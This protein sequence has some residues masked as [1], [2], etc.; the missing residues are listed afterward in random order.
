MKRTLSL[1][2]LLVG[3]IAFSAPASAKMIEVIGI[4]VNVDITT[5][6]KV[7]IV[8]L[9]KDAPAERGGLVNANDQ[10]IAV[11]NVP[12]SGFVAVAG[13]KIEDV[14]A[15]I[16]GPE[17]VVVGLKLVRAGSPELTVNVVRGKFMVDDGT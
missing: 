14:G 7:M 12:G 2:S 13:K 9:I 3:L 16:R 11:Q 1:V 10:I 8:S 15:L 17:G 4:G 5:D 6:G